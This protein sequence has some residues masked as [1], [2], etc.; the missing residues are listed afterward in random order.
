VV[1]LEVVLAA[2]GDGST[3]GVALNGTCG[4]ATGW[5]GLAV[6]RS[7]RGV[8][9][10]SKATSHSDKKAISA[11]DMM[12]EASSSV[13]LGTRPRR[14]ER[15]IRSLASVAWPKEEAA[16]GRQCRREKEIREAVGSGK[17]PA[18]WRRGKAKALRMTSGP[19]RI[20]NLTDFSSARIQNLKRCF[21]KAP[22][23]MYNF[24]VTEEIKGN[25]FLFGLNFKIEK[26]FELQ[27]QERTI[28]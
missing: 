2:A 23:F 18:Q 25:N 9:R 27:I 21:S 16:L 7:S 24:E 6:A 22:K 4:A 15:R 19:R 8:L 13:A 14:A 17:W 26:N 12:A 28:V 1:E 3:G 11:S 10:P 20:L 5:L